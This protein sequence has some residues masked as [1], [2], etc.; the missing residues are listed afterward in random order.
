MLGKACPDHHG[1][2]R[3]HVIGCGVHRGGAY[4]TGQAVGVAP[5][6]VGEGGVVLLQLG[7]LGSTLPWSAPARPVLLLV[8]T[9]LRLAAAAAEVFL[10]FFLLLLLLL[11]LLFPAPWGS[12]FLDVRRE[13]GNAHHGSD[14]SH[15]GAYVSLSIKEIIRAP[16][17]C[18][19]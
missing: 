6:L 18:F 13:K 11:G 5:A 9:A 2:Q 8:V 15:V 19:P 3:R 14:R 7:W 1:N 17:N 16:W 4:K 10:R 12:V